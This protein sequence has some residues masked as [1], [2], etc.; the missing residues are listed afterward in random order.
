MEPL[1]GAR[2]GGVSFLIRGGKG[3]GGS[4]GGGG[5]GG[6]GLGASLVELFSCVPP[7]TCASVVAAIEILKQHGKH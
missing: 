7:V 1:G 2:G 3:G 5:G 4:G 6:I